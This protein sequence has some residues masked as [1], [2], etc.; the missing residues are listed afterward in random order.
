MSEYRLGTHRGKYVVVWTDAAGNRKRHSLGTADRSEAKALF[1]RA[2]A[3]LQRRPAPEAGT[4][5]SLFDAYIE[6]KKIEGKNTARMEF[7]Q[8]ALKDHFGHI[9]PNDLTIEMAQDYERKAKKR[10]KSAATI[11][12]ELGYLRT[13]L[14]Y[15]KKR[16]WLTTETYVWVSEKGAP[17]ERHLS[18]EE[19][20]QLVDAC[21]LP[22]MKLFVALALTTAGR[23]GAVLD[24]TWDRV[25]LKRGIID[26]KNPERG[27]TRKGRATVPISD[28]VVPML[29]DARRGAISDWV[30]EWGG[31]KLTKINKGFRAAVAR[32]GLGADVT[33]HTLRHT[34]AVWMAEAGVRMEE[35][36]QYLGHTDSRT[37]YRVYARYSPEY[38]KKANKALSL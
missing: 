9:D 11:H 13:C 37:T 24:L 23:A 19:A 17:R 25:N 31:K 5:D 7:V 12:T 18:R 4:I 3:D 20:R 30:V 1:A 36:A 21:E 14:S 26:L 2:I 29:Q 6:A 32:A 15:A 16:K 22:H 34:A 33:P 28:W 35:I 8:I 10:G 27:E 38:L